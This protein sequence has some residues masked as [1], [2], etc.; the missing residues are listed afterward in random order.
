MMLL[1]LALSTSLLF[2]VGSGSTAFHNIAPELGVATAASSWSA[3]TG[4]EKAIDG[5]T[6]GRWIPSSNSN[7]LYCSKTPGPSVWLKI[8]FP[9]QPVYIDHI[10]VWNRVDYPSYRTR[11]D[12]VRVMVDDKLVSTLVYTSNSQLQ[13]PI[14]NIKKTGSSVTLWAQRISGGT[15]DGY[16]NFGEVE[17]FG[18][19]SD[20]KCVSPYG[21]SYNAG[22]TYMQ[23]E[24]TCTCGS[25]GIVCAC[26]GELAA[27]CPTGQNKWTDQASC[28]ASCIPHNAICTSS[29]DP[30]YGTFDGKYFDFH[31]VCT[32]Q[33]ASCGD[34]KV[35]YKNVDFF[36]RA[37]RFTL[38]VEL[39]Y[40]GVTYAIAN[41]YQALVNGQ[42]VQVPY[43]KSF[44]NGD[45]VEILNNG[46]ME[47]RLQQPG[48]SKAPAVVIRA[49]D[50][51]FTGGE[52][53]ITGE[54]VLHGSCAGLTEGLCGNWNGNPSDDLTGGSAN[55]LGVLHQLFDENCPAPPDPYHPCDMLGEDGHKDAAAVCDTMKNAPF[56]QCHETVSYGTVEEGP[57]YNCMADVCECLLDKNCGCNQF[58][59]YASTCIQNGIDLANWRDSVEF[60]P[61]TCPAGLMYSSAGPVPTPT[62]LDR[63]PEVQSTTRGCF[64]PSG[65][66][67]QDGVC[68]SP[69]QCKCLYEGVFYLLGDVVKED[70]LCKTCTCAAAGEMS[71]VPFECPTLSCGP[72]EI[73]ASNNDE[74]C[75]YCEANWVEAINPE[76]KVLAGAVVVLTCQI[77]APDVTDIMWTGG[78]AHSDAAAGR[79][80]EDGRTFKITTDGVKN[81]G[82]YICT[83][84]KEGSTASAEFKLEV[85]EPKPVEPVKPVKPVKPVEPVEPK[86]EV[87]IKAA[88]GK[89]CKAKKNCTIRFKVSGVEVGSNDGKICQLIDGEPKNCKKPKYRKGKKEFSAKLGKRKG[90]PASAA[91]KWVLVVTVDGKEV[92]GGEMEVSV[93]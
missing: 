80:S 48:K 54:I 42:T 91:G 9:K 87:T 92:V 76:V 49:Y 32:Y 30:H 85:V 4:P 28:T 58:D 26:E 36:N 34:F 22:D 68:V 55:S 64:C 57:Y 61:Y 11:I 88:K 47:I 50:Q 10:V 15:R 20:V 51:V 82:T 37:P 21:S 40:M 39:E 14:N 41:R 5:N 31:G 67:L 81:S 24:K 45:S 46:Q 73:K 62:C 56:A 29:G 66:F 52:S 70:P 17:V 77:N 25:R 71:C 93:N 2:R 38:R 1:L 53:Y 13:Y 16:L 74:C 75:P 3:F 69:D 23:G 33:A 18:A 44:T 86:P 90:T 27:A 84:T 8:S 65:Q 79:T 19:P 35:N 7:S 43:V 72:G 89:T 60:C 63:E 78:P 83:A 6:N 59:N 12:G